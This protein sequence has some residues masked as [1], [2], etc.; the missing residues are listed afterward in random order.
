ML[1]AEWSSFFRG[2]GI[3]EHVDIVIVHQR[4]Q[5]AAEGGASGVC[6]EVGGARFALW[7]GKDVG[8]VAGD[9]RFEAIVCGDGFERLHRETG[10]AAQIGR[11]VMDDVV[12]VHEKRGGSSAFGLEL[13]K[14]CDLDY[15]CAAFGEGR[16]NVSNARVCRCVVFEPIIEHAEAQPREVHVAE[17][18][19][20]AA[21]DL[22]ARLGGLGVRRVIADGGVQ[23]DR[24]VARA[25][26]QRTTDV[27]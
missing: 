25:T 9:D 6:L 21:R 26:C 5:L 10:V 18:R 8:L 22:A 23:H 17:V 16:E 7:G 12:V 2:G 3:D 24:E 27:A 15:G 20:I 11:Q 14:V 1:L 19:K 13:G 4:E